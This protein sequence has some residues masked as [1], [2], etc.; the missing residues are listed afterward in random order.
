MSTRQD[1]D[2]FLAFLHETFVVAREDSGYANSNG[3]AS[4]ASA[5]SEH[6]ES[7]ASGQQGCVPQAAACC[8][9]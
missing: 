8:S 9:V 5:R 6:L 2:R 1:V 4:V 3:N 7:I